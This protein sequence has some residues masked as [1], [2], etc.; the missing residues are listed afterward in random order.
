ME[1]R[2]LAN[3]KLHL[4]ESEEELRKI[5]RRALKCNPAYFRIVKKSLDARD[6]GNI[7]YVYTI[8]FAAKELSSAQIEPAVERLPKEKQ[9][10]RNK[11]VLIVGAGPA[12]LF[13][14]LRLLKRGIAPL[15]IERGE[16][17][18]RREKTL[19]TF[20]ETGVLNTESNVSFGEGGAGTFPTENSTRARTLKKTTKSCANLSVSARPKKSR[21]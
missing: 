16:S 15:L 14:A 2:R 20:H 10:D 19:R 13:C 1:I 18:E 6:K 21:I 4:G 9:P 5:A 12:G 7:F 8:E 11:P 17:V 3:I